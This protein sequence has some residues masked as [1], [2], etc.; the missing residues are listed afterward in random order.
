LISYLIPCYEEE[1]QLTRD[2]GYKH[3]MF[4][5]PYVPALGTKIQ[6]IDC[7]DELLER[8]PESGLPGW[9]ATPHI[10]LKVIEI[11]HDINYGIIAVT[12]DLTINWM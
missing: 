6:L 7:F 4:T 3:P 10:I 11:R 2:T 12:C 8:S 1:H 5:Y 9:S